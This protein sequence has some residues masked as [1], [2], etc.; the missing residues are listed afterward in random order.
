M[1]ICIE[2]EIST[3][4]LPPNTTQCKR[5]LYASV[6]GRCSFVRDC[7]GDLLHQEC[8]EHSPEWVVK[9]VPPLG[10]ATDEGVP[11]KRLLHRLKRWCP[12]KL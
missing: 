8:A 4:L 9:Q 11:D 10:C 1:D 7:T 6:V 5:A 12:P 3:L 2:R